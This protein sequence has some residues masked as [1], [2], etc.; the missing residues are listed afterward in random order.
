MDTSLDTIRAYFLK[1]GLETELAD[2]YTA[3]HSHGPQSISELSRNSNVERTRIY[4]LID[5]LM[6]TSLIEVETQAKRGIV[7]AAPISNLRILIN[8]RQEALQ[9]L[10][11]ELSLIEQALARNSLSNPAMRVQLYHG[12]EGLRRMMRNSLRAKTELLHMANRIT[13]EAIGKTHTNT[14]ADEFESLG[15]QCRTLVDSNYAKSQQT[16]KRSGI[17][18]NRE[19]KGIN[20]VLV[21]SQVFRIHIWCITYDNVVAYCHWQDGEVFGTELYNE[22][23]ASSQRQLFESI[24]QQSQPP[25][26]PTN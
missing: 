8:Q 4:R 2:I 21:P 14:W 6:E 20:C 5:R 12:P 9:N 7:K 17:T 3:L 10:Q 1:L 18:T 25:V 16:G 22:G 13:E 23:L 24:W 11:D 19:I 26:S 15:L